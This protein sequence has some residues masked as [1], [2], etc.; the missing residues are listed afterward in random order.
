MFR[1]W[2]EAELDDAQL[3]EIFGFI[4][5]PHL[6]AAHAGRVA[7]LLL[8]WLETPEAPITVGL[9]AQANVITAKSWRDIDREASPEPC[10][11]WHSDAA[12]GPA[13]TLAKYWLRQR[14]LLRERPNSFPDT[15]LKGAYGKPWP[16]GSEAVA[17]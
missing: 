5:E 2:R 4:R 15:F 12:G 16:A 9:L 14:S 6:S 7:D 13:G 3:D 17:R 1:V 8:A 11:S 10:D